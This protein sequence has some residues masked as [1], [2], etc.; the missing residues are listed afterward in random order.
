MATL[1]RKRVGASTRRRSLFALGAASAIVVPA[2][3]AVACVPQASIGFNSNSYRYSPGD[4]VGV[5]GRGFVQNSQVTL[6]LSPPG[7]VV[8]NGVTTDSQGNFS[9]SFG[10]PADTPHGTYVVEARTS[11][12]PSGGGMGGPATVARESF[13][14]GPP[15]EVLL[16]AAIS[17]CKKKYSTKRIRGSAR[18]RAAA[19]KRMVRK[20]Q[21]CIQ[22]ARET[23]R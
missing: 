10:L 4:T 13:T 20:R 7:R 1:F 16:N 5:T 6:T 12:S 2:A 9:D 3:I 8:G 22:T 14:V 23:I 21:R 17:Q 11:G 19:R 18:R 15:R